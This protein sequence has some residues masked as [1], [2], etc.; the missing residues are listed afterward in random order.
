M[1]TSLAA[2]DYRYAGFWWRFVAA[3]IDGVIGTVIGMV[4]GAVIGFQMGSGDATID[5]IKAV[6]SVVGMVV[7]WLY[8][9]ISESSPMSGTLGKYLL[10]IRVVDENGDRIG[11]GRATGRYFGKILSALILCV[12]FLMAGWTRRK[13]A[14][15]DMIAGCLV[16]RRVARPDRI[17]LPG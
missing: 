4:V 16:V 6:S 17:H 8:F 2:S 9:A 7:N 13:Q 15:H 1:G 12:G 11:F 5:A 3:L 10:G 14:L